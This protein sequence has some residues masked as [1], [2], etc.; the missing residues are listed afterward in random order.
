[1]ASTENN[2]SYDPI[3]PGMI[4]QDLISEMIYAGIYYFSNL[5]PCL[6]TTVFIFIRYGF[7]IG[8]CMVQAASG[9]ANIMD[10]A[11]LT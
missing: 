9:G 5:L 10:E 2:D 6:D 11:P 7:G 8:Y 1:M 4:K 3:E